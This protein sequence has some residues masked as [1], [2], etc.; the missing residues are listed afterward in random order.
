M[1]RTVAERLHGS[2][3]VNR[4]Y[5]PVAV[6]L[7]WALLAAPSDQALAVQL[8]PEIQADLYEEQLEQRLEERDFEGA[9]ETL[10]QIRMLRQDHGLEIPDVFYFQYAEVLQ[11]LGLYEAAV[12]ELTRYLTLA[13]QEGEHYQTALTML[14]E[15]RESLEDLLGQAARAGA[16]EMVVIPAGRFRMGCVSGRYCKDDELPVHEVRV[17]SF[18]LSKYEVTREEYAAFVV[19]TRHTMS[20]DCIGGGGYALDP[21]ERVLQVTDDGSWS[22]PGFEQGDGHPVVCV[23]WE[24]AQAYARWLSEQTGQDYR[25]PSEAEWEYAAR[26]GTT[27]DYTWGNDDDEMCRYA[28]GPDHSL[29]AAAGVMMQAAMFDFW[30]N[31]CGDGVAWTAPVGSYVPND[32]GLHDM[33][34]NVSEWVEDCWHENYAGA[35][36]DG[37]AW[38]SGG[39]CG[40]R[41]LRGGSWNSF[42]G[43]NSA[44][45]RGYS[46][47]ERDSNYGFRV[48]RTLTP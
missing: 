30:Y 3:R 26:A 31:D 25:L 5:L 46:T 17:A 1:E 35:P 16:P 41:V 4:T 24:D 45:R 47:G 39:D 13:G 10:D 21:D 34:G 2:W 32:F 15:S 29:R 38:I 42:R 20:A 40:D 27:T 44:D 37:T 12:E 8:P 9:Q 19:A 11:Q 14:I 22:D 36:T 23:I 43:H 7:A 48:A 6:L 28:N 18:A 33:V